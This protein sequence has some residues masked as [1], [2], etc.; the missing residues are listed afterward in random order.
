MIV[1]IYNMSI[2]YSHA[3]ANHMLL[4]KLASNPH[5]ASISDQF[6]AEPEDRLQRLLGLPLDLAV[7]THERKTKWLSLDIS[8]LASSSLC[9]HIISHPSLGLNRIRYLSRL[10]RLH[11]N[12]AG[13]R[14]CSAGYAC[15]CI[16]SGGAPSPGRLW[17]SRKGWCQRRGAR[18]CSRQAGSWPQDSNG[19]ASPPKSP[20]FLPNNSAVR[21][22]CSHKQHKH[23]SE[24]S[25]G[26]I[27][28]IFHKM[29]KITRKNNS[30]IWRSKYKSKATSCVILQ[31]AT[32]SQHQQDC[33]S[34]F[35]LKSSLEVSFYWHILA[36]IGTIW[37]IY[38][39]LSFCIL[40][41]TPWRK[42]PGKAT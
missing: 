23:G 4:W 16:V 2:K 37:W 26:W 10:K 35:P 13:H 34:S 41:Q 21:Y 9:S 7:K 29:P 1:Y 32:G 33:E 38:M 27:T 15:H 22:S 11:K 25:T 8:V 6:L 12:H 42:Q 20:T 19:F 3:C 14:I 31:Y 28:S 40:R 18:R 24:I 39:A 17:L 5:C 30:T 36:H